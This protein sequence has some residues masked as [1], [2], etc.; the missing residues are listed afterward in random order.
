MGIPDAARRGA[1]AATPQAR[2]SLFPHAGS[3]EATSRARGAAW[4]LGNLSSTRE[5]G[6]RGE[7]V[8]AA[9]LEELRS[10]VE[11]M[12][13]DLGQASIPENS[14]V[15]SAR[16][17]PRG[18]VRVQRW[19]NRDRLGATLRRRLLRSPVSPHSSFN[20]LGEAGKNMY[21]VLCAHASLC[22][23]LWLRGLVGADFHEPANASSAQLSTVLVACSA[24]TTQALH[25]SPR[26]FRQKCVQMVQAEARE[27]D[28][29]QGLEC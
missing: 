16:G 1:R 28:R 12:A 27:N 8:G 24:R 9:P 3:S 29:D 25:K 17:G 6:A 20:R 23:V 10:M 15:A 11:R 5:P 26:S 4:E 22:A 21:A 13:Q 18:A 19:A 7:G 2:R 14:P